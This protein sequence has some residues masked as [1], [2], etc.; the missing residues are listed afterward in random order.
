MGYL[1]SRMQLYGYRRLLDDF[2]LFQ[3][4]NKSMLPQRWKGGGN[5]LSA[6]WLISQR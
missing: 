3:R 5:P 6:L 1:I 4:W 2:Y